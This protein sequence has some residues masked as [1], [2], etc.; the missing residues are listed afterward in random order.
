MVII[1]WVTFLS[2]VFL[3][4][5][6][7]IICGPGRENFILGF[8]PFLFSFYSQ[9][10]E[11][12]F[13]PLIFLHMFSILPKFH[14]TKHSVKVMQRIP[15]SLV[16]FFF[17]GKLKTSL[18]IKIRCTEKKKKKQVHRECIKETKR[19]TKLHNSRK[20]NK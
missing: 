19:Y 9:T 18:N 7:E 12:T 14:P 5:W 8:S 13:I 17:S 3:P 4:I 1:L 20:S 6:E 11:N 16:N 2:W 15:P 10:V